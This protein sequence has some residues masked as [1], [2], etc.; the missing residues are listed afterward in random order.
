MTYWLVIFQTPPLIETPAPLKYK[1][2]RARY[3]AVCSM[4]SVTIECDKGNFEVVSK[5]MFSI[6]EYNAAFIVCS[7]KKHTCS[8]P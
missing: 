5:K 1:L 7:A 8:V 4:D 6:E 2:T 3:D